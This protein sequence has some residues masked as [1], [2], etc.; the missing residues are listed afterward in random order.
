MIICFKLILYN[1]LDDHTFG[2]SAYSFDCTYFRLIFL[3]AKALH[4]MTMRGFLFGATEPEIRTL[5]RIQL[6]ILG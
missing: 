6:R 4:S 1:K 3:T 5:K 2:K